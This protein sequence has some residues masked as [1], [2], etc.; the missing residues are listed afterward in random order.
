ML[1]KP[2]LWWAILGV[3]LSLVMPTVG[4]AIVLLFFPDMRFAHLPVHSLLETSGGLM[5][6]AIAGIL[7]VEFR[8]KPEVVCYL[9]MASALIA[10]GI[11]DTFHAAV[12]PGNAFVWLHSIATL[13]GGVIFATVW[14]E[15]SPLTIRSSRILIWAV[16]V[17][18]CLLGLHA[19]L[20]PAQIPAMVAEGNFTPLARALNICGG[21]GFLIAGLF[22][23]RRFHLYAQHESWLFAVHTM[24]LGAAGILFEMSALWDMAWWWWHFLRIVAYS[25][26]LAFALRA[27]LATEHRLRDLNRQLQNS[28]Q[29]LD[30]TVAIRTQELRAKEERFKLAV[31]GSTDGLWD[32]N[33]LTNKVYYATRFKELLGLKEEEMSDGF[34][35]FESR[36]HPDDYEPTQTALNRHIEE[37]EP[38][39]VEYRLRLKN[40]DYRWF[41]ARGQ[42][43]WDARG[44]AVR[45]AGSITDIHN[46][47]LAEAALEY[48]QFLLETL[49]NH[50]PDE[51]TF[52]D[53]EGRFL[54][55]S[56]ALARR[57]KVDNPK[58]LEGLSNFD[59]FPA[60]YARKR[61]EQEKELMQSGRSMLRREE[62]LQG[63]SGENLTMLTTKIPLRNRQGKV[64]GTFGIAHDI[65]E[66]KRAEERFRLVVEAT[67]NPILLVNLSGRIQ[68]ANWAAFEMFGYQLDILIGM[69]L[70]N[71]F[72][73]HSGDMEVQNLRELLNHPRA[74]LLTEPQ[75]VNG[76]CQ[77]GRVL[78]LEVR[79][80]PVEI[81][82]EQLVLISLFDMTVHKQVDET[83][84]RAR[85]AAEQAN[86]EKSLFLANMSHEIRT[87]L[88]AI[89]GISELLL[90]SSPT[91]EQRE[92]LTIVLESGESL[93]SII[94]DLLDFSKIEAGKLELEA[95]PFDLR[96]EIGKVFRLLSSHNRKKDLNITWQVDD[97][98][99]QTLIG[100]PVHLRQVLMNLVGNAIKFTMRG[101]VQLKVEHQK[102]AE[103][104]DVQLLFAV[105]DTGIG[106][107]AKHLENIFSR[108]VQAD[109]STTRQFGGSGLGLTITT[110]IIAAM[111][112]RIWA[113][114]EEG[115]GSTFRFVITLPEAG[116]S[117]EAA[118]RE[119]PTSGLSQKQSASSQTPSMI[120]LPP[121]RILVAE[122]GMSNQRLVKALLE[123][124]G[125][126]VCIAENGRIAVDCCH[127]EPFDLIL[128]DVT[129]PEMDG[130][131]A[132]RC[133]REQ[134]VLT[135]Q[136]IPIIAMTARAMPADI[137]KCLQSGMDGY[138]A[139]PLHKQDLETAI[140]ELFTAAVA[141]ETVA[142]EEKSK[143]LV[144]WSE[145]L[146]VVEGDEELLC[147]L[148]K[149]SLTELPN[150]MDALE[151]D[152]SASDAAE[153]YRHA[154]TTKAAARTFGIPVLLTQAERTEEAAANGDLETVEKELPAL[155]SIVNQTLFELEQ[156][157]KHEV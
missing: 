93:L 132:T 155:R 32:W 26:A 156:R 153:A 60:E 31:A 131:T 14:M 139:K 125:H 63:P 137:K 88:N 43:I 3:M 56:A 91:Y 44:L 47:K 87:P 84:E 83:L 77:D 35:E 69:T 122:D 51:I 78:P 61:L 55:V 40:G 119:V 79:L 17:C 146:Q 71:L 95:V 42:A 104:G 101:E 128:M 9:S 57:L 74:N 1:G 143:S 118:A 94:N 5:A 64:I 109:S 66:I 76:I 117:G 106:I 52:K 138:L 41:R 36:L 18:S 151:R 2:T 45:M 92:F 114:S 20:L 70:E 116:A 54:R 99:P 96:Q 115:Q 49:L 113:E 34:F 123:K 16:L 121:L 12:E 136:H 134:E 53:T 15:Y 30:K 10:M 86:E 48:E 124:W 129:M 112:G 108:F 22:F 103:Q 90:D 37:Q 72:S 27:Y 58:A 38:Y 120:S 85:K 144:N 102:T 28:N 82:D 33:L 133:I 130:L 100:D 7:V 75:E 67:P 148:I 105:R 150:L 24:L 39:D 145:A 65:T 59:F 68:L 142:P 81:D 135:G 140:A 11:L 147:E 80:I 110:R 157:L 19:C 23:I 25:A 8:R 98:I 127:C 13:A 107:P 6:V 50:L 111:Q 149:D 126:T 73:Q 46:Q 154:H 21:V 4:S 89:I 141:E 29:R 152:L 62:C 97:S